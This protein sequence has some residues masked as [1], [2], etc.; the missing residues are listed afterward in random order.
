MIDLLHLHDV[1]HVDE[2]P[3]CSEWFVVAP[4]LRVP[5]RTCPAA[6]SGRCPPGC[7]HRAG[8]FRLNMRDG[9]S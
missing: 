5:T 2:N 8:V 7:R 1:Q 9:Q 4:M 6:G 3:G